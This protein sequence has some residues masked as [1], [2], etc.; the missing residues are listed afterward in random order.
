MSAKIHLLSDETINQIAAGEVIESPASVVKELVENA[1]DAG[2]K[3]ISVELTGGGLKLIRVVD[4]GSGMSLEDARFCFL[5][6]ATSKITSAHDLFHIQTKGFRGEALASIASIAKVTMQTALEEGVAVEL[7]LERGA[8][9]SERSCVRKRGTTL[10]VRSLFYNVPARKKFQKSSAAISAEIF[11][12]MTEMALCHPEVAFELSSNGRQTLK[13]APSQEPKERIEELLGRAFVSESFSLNFEEG[14]FAIQGVLGA[15]TCHRGNRLGQHLFLNQRAVECEPIAE[16]VRQGYGTRMEARRYPIFC[17]WM[18]VPADLVDVNVH[19]QKL[20]VRLRKEELF[21]EKV[22]LAVEKALAPKFSMPRVAPAH[23]EPVAPLGFS[24]EP[25]SF[26]FEEEEEEAPLELP[27]VW[28]QMELMGQLGRFV[29]FK[30]GESV[31]I[32]DCKAA[33]YRVHYEELLSKGEGAIE[34]QGLLLPFTIDLT[35]VEG[36]MVLT[37]ID[38]IEAFGFELRAIA[39]DRF[40]VEATPPHVEGGAVGKLIAEMGQIL[41]EFIGKLDYKRERKKKLALVAAR[42]VTT[43]RALSQEELVHLYK[44]LLAC[45]CP[46][47][48]PKGT[49][50]LVELRDESIEDLFKTYRNTASG[51][52]K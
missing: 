24:D 7:E 20:T 50:T 45:E 47:S 29:F 44:R 27:M 36:A 37:H 16:A 31:K 30:E 4:D 32:M 19:P 25:L 49:P 2:A 23:F 26:C 18:T 15:P 40:M 9:V 41:Q 46:F 48:C 17:L 51:A 43:K 38:A 34:K 5:R 35:P 8:I 39:K 28:E 6:H 22:I 13:V 11:K 12:R 52:A 3:K 21:V 33:S 1:L 14:G 42:Y 10:E